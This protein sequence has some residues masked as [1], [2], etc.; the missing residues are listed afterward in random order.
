MVGMSFYESIHPDDIGFVEIKFEEL[1]AQGR[2]EMEVRGLRKD[3]SIFYMQVV[4]VK[5]LASDSSSV[6]HYCFMKDITEHILNEHK[7][8]DSLFRD[9]RCVYYVETKLKRRIALL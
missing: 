7:L 2:I 8:I 3:K 6:H 1:L 5:G 9:R 4:L